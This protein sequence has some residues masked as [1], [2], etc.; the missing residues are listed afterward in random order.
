MRRPHLE[1]HLVVSAEV[2]RLH[3]APSPEIPEMDPVTVLIRKQVLWDDSVLELRR[4]PPFARDH[5]VTRQIPPEVIV[6][7]L[8]SAIDLPAAEDIERL[9]VHDEDARRTVGAIFAT[10]AK[11]AHV[12]PFRPAMDRMRPRV[13]S[14]FEHL[15]RFND[16]VNLRFGRIWF[17]IDDVEARGPDPG[18]DQVAPL[19][20]CVAGEWRQG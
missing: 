17:R 13:A 9:A 15:L 19:E 8:G 14:P 12:D 1:Y 18:D 4:Q 6:Q 2:D 7:V 3:V 20:E 11:R 10:A 16:L 5:V